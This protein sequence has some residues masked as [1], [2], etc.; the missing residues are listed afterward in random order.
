MQSGNEYQAVVLAALIHGVGEFV[1][2]GKFLYLDTGQYQKFSVFLAPRTR[3]TQKATFKA[4]PAVSFV[5]KT[6][7]MTGK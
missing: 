7:V 3:G 4:N 1:Y 5:A 6:H 2:C